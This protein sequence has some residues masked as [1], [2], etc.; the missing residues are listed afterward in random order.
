MF[1]A[2]SCS[3]DSVS[4]VT[5]G[6]ETENTSL[7]ELQKEVEG[8]GSSHQLWGLYQF[9]VDPDARTVEFTPLRDAMMHLNALSFLEPPVFVLLTLENDLV[10]NGSQL[11][12]DV[13]LRHPFLG[14]NEFTGFDVRGILISDGNKSGFE[15]PALRIAWEGATRLLN[16]DGLTRWWNPTEFPY[17][18]VNQLF[19]YKDGMLGTPD[20]QAN[21]SATLNGFKYFSDDLGRN[22]GLEELTAEHRGYFTA[23][24]KNVRHYK[25]DLGDGLVFNYAID[26]SWE[27][28]ITQPP[29]T[30][31]DVPD[32]FIMEA[33]APEPY[34]V[35][36]T[37]LFNNLWSTGSE[38]GGV[39]EFHVLVHTF[40]DNAAACNVHVEW[41]GYIPQTTG[42]ILDIEDHLSINA[43]I[44]SPIDVPQNQLPLLIS[45]ESDEAG[46]QDILPGEPVAS[47][48]IHNFDVSPTKPNEPPV[49]IAEA[50]TAT[51]IQQ[52]ETVEFDG[53]ASYDMDGTI[54]S[55][56]WESDDD[57]L[58]DDAA[59]VNPIIQFDEIG[60]FYVD[61]RV[62]DND[63]ATDTLDSLIEIIV[64][65]PNEPPVAVAWATTSTTIYEGETVIFTCAGSYDPDG[66]I[67]DRDWEMGDDSDY[68]DGA[69]IVVILQFNTAGNY[70][71]DVRVTDNL[72]AT[73][74]LDTKILVQ[75]FEEPF[76]W[77][78]E[79]PDPPPFT[80]FRYNISFCSLFYEDWDLRYD[81]PGGVQYADTGDNYYFEESGTNGAL[82][83]P[84]KIHTAHQFNS[85]VTDSLEVPD[86]TG[87]VTLSLRHYIDLLYDDLLGGEYMDGAQVRITTNLNDSVWSTPSNVLSQS[88]LLYPT[89]GPSYGIIGSSFINNHLNGHMGFRGPLNSWYT[90]TFNLNAYKGQNV[91]IG[92][93]FSSGF[94]AMMGG[95]NWNGGMDW[96]YGIRIGRWEIIAN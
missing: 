57:D 20:S 49:A 68:N 18:S 3:G 64:T 78:P 83:D 91:R 54:V 17:N 37:E 46:Y 48:I 13:G 32:C 9:N 55:Y 87:N 4:P 10:F 65:P 52:G 73:D 60:T 1:L 79:D 19:G 76:H 28:P 41:P 53:S 70:Y 42:D 26:A 33:N 93:V 82:S 16:T 84:D 86:P 5:P 51:T 22:D 11:D 34:Y 77:D 61:L 96:R 94:Y 71:V 80:P 35:E 40:R 90:S 43:F 63:S 39:I 15:D 88:T 62:T 74:T 31:D 67:T 85:L 2:V 92:Y 81:P 56:E 95:C 89:S 8:N 69:G 27:F 58:Y 72:G 44:I 38:S 75:V 36:V 30:D 47:Y 25:L 29:W 50:V 6:T 23:G 21:F 59:G 12:V 7:P 66:T 24:K 45:V 14:L